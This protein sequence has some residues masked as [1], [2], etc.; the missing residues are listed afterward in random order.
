MYFADI[1]TPSVFCH[2]LNHALDFTCPE[3]HYQMNS[4][5]S[6]IAPVQFLILHSYDSHALNNLLSAHSQL[7]EATPLPQTPKTSKASDV[8]VFIPLD[9]SQ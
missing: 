5:T 2:P 8:S 1:I 9:A 3:R 6:P 7:E 4:A